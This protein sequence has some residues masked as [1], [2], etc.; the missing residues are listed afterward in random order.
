MRRAA[1]LAVGWLIAAAA[2]LG[3]AGCAAEDRVAQGVDMANGRIRVSPHPSDP[4][5]LRVEATNM[6]SFTPMGTADDRRRMVA[7]LLADQCGEPAIVDARETRVL[8]SP[9]GTPFRS[10]TLTVRCPNGASSPVE[11]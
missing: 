4:T 3:L 1:N 11:R 6:G 7:A 9:S 5:L 2:A 8:P 10:Y